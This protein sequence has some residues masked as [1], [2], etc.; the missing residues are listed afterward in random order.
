MEDRFVGSM[1]GLALADALGSEH[2]GGV[3]AGNIWKLIYGRGNELRWTDDT[4]MAVGLAESLIE[5]NGIEPDRLAKRWAERMQ[6]MR[7]YGEGARELLK[8]VKQGVDWREAN[9]ATFPNGSYGNGAAMRAAPLGL[10]YYR[11]DDKLRQATTLASSI[12]HAHP[13]GIEGGLLIAKATALAL[14][15]PLKPDVFLQDLYEFC[16]RDEF[17]L[18]LG[19]ARK[20]LKE[21]PSNAVIVS[22]L[23][24]GVVAHKSAVT[25]VYAFCRHPDDFKALIEFI[26]NLGG[27]TDTIGAMAG[28]IFG[29]KNGTAALPA[30]LLP[31]LEA[32]ED[33]EKLGRALFAAAH[34]K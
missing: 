1:L 16:E 21:N 20:L 27:D 13:L 30:D 28:G 31:R 22:Q 6:G 32:R 2:E 15:E 12:T 25:A 26:I 24:T 19:I 5:N 33:L 34:P 18:R 14:H 9:T 4:E 23:G 7:G 17:R 3:I 11:D 10:F 8:M 29:A